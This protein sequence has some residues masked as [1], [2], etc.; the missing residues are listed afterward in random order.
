MATQNKGNNT[1]AGLTGAKAGDGKPGPV[2]TESTQTAAD[3]SDVGEAGGTEGTQESTTVIDQATGN[4]T[5]TSGAG[6]STTSTTESESTGVQDASGA[7]TVLAAVDL[8]NSLQAPVRTSVDTATETPTVG[9][10]A[11]LD[12]QPD[13]DTAI[14]HST[15]AEE[16]M[17]ADPMATSV[18]ESFEAL[19][20]S[21]IPSLQLGP[22]QFERGLLKF[23]DSAKA[24]AF[25]ELLDEQPVQ[26]K[27]Q[28][29]KVNVGAANQLVRDLTQGRM[30][31]GVDTSANTLQAPNARPYSG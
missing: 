3:T 4:E 23:D 31:T 10:V 26:L 24:A 15:L 7:E 9:V 19:Y 13:A 14:S 28:V 11:A 20:S 12:Q 30:I 18:V 17:A 22:Y 1:F 29:R 5:T 16:Q 27:N 21:S 2:E 8:A 25:E 6:A